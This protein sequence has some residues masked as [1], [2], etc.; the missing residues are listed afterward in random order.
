MFRILGSI[1]GSRCPGEQYVSDFAPPDFGIHFGDPA[2]AFR[3]PFGVAVL[4]HQP[5]CR[6]LLSIQS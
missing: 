2:G 3:D 5:R 1:W 4:V 6:C